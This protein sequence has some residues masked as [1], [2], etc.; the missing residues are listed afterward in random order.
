LVDTAEGVVKPSTVGGIGRARWVRRLIEAAWLLLVVAIAA[1]LFTARFYDPRRVAASGDSYWYMIEAE[2][3]AGVDAAT[4]ANRAAAQI[5]RDAN[6]SAL[7]SHV[8]KGCTSY[9]VSWVPQKYRRI[10]ETRPGYPLFAAPFVR[11][12]GLWRG[13]AAATMALA[14]IAAALAYLAVWLATGL[15]TAGVVASVLFFLLPSGFWMT[16]MLAEGGVA[17]G[18]FAVLIGAMLVWRGRWPGLIVIVA[19]MG[20]LFAV[21][22]A[23]GMAAAVALTGAALLA[24]LTRFQN[25]RALA[26]TGGLG[27]LVIAVWQVVTTVFHLP[28]LGDSIQDFATFHW[29]R[30]LVPDPAGWLI[31]KNLEYWPVQGRALLVSPWPVV[32]F[33]F[34]G[35]VLALRMRQPAWLW[36]VMGLTG[37]MM[38]LAHPADGEWDR[39]MLPLWMP[40]SCALGYAAARALTRSPTPARTDRPDEARDWSIK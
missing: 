32:L 28:G 20:W 11:V 4:A 26:A 9:D 3:Y 31:D 30:P 19:A 39:M 1:G 14:L 34:A 35:V 38:M 27:V 22:S 8:K 21:R 33:V 2:K 16:R 7:Q 13:M 23:S 12:F 10:F 15:R 25:R 36:V 37:V 18:Y 24:L 5:C 6:R 17:V 40:V 29:T